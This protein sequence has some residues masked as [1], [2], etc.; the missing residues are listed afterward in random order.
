MSLFFTK[1]VPRI[2]IAFANSVQFP[3]T[4]NVPHPLL[5]WTEGALG[6]RERP[7]QG[8]LKWNDWA[9]WGGSYRDKKGPAWGCKAG[10]HLP[11]LFFP[12]GNTH[13]RAGRL[14]CG[15]GSGLK[16]IPP[17]PVYQGRAASSSF[18][19]KRWHFQSRSLFYD[20]VHDSLLSINI[21]V[22]GWNNKEARG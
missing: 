6:G 21:S 8:S 11:T 19:L 18:L 16:P 13:S 3:T 2:W 22:L 10:T 15:A 20:H 14:H 5:W 4:Y 7:Y 9:S 17:C 1:F 12:P